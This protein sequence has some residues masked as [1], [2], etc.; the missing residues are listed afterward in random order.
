MINCK[1]SAQFFGAWLGLVASVFCVATRAETP[2]GNFTGS[3][4]HTWDG[5]AQLGMQ[6]RTFEQPHLINANEK[7]LRRYLQY[8]PRRVVGQKSKRPLVIALPGADLSA[9]AFREWDLGDRLERLAEKEKFILVYA[10]AFAPSRLEEKN[11]DNPFFANGGYWRTCFGRPGDGPEF[12]AVDDVDYLRRVIEN[13]KR[14]GLPVDSERIYLMGMSNGGEMAQRAA[15]SMG[16]ELAGVGAVMPVNA[17]PATVELFTCPVAEQ[18]PVSMMF[19]YS[20]KD[21]LLQPIYAGFGFSYAEQM[22]ETLKAWRTALGIDPA[23]ETVRRL[24]NK[25]REGEGYSGD[26]PWTLA[27]MNSTIKRYDYAQAPSGAGFSVLEINDTAG[28]AWPNY[29]PT[30]HDVASQP[31]NGFKNQDIQAEE[32]LWRFLKKSKRI[33]KN[34]K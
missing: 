9:E 26:V 29:Q 22:S 20:P 5:L 6:V 3:A 31:D 27:S 28:H 16:G 11:P 14:E 17:M 10:N 1:Y 32:E 19:I 18:K 15:R 30:P 34:G 24:P 21:I 4:H 7:V 25:N 2:I 13:V 23:T 12:F 33:A 8:V